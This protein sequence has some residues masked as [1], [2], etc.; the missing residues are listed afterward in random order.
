VSIAIFLSTF[1]AVLHKNNFMTPATA[2]FAE[3]E[4]KTS[5][6]EPLKPVSTP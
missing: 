5:P 2:V 1:L 4:E 3:G 6:V